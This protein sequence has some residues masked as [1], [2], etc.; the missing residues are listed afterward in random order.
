MLLATSFCAACLRIKSTGK[1]TVS[2]DKYPS[3]IYLACQYC[4]LHMNGIVSY[5]VRTM[6]AECERIHKNS[7]SKEKP[8][9]R[10]SG[11]PE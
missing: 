3:N 6:H 8:V 10:L 9:L 4:G 5:E 2:G 7:P 1:I 11:V